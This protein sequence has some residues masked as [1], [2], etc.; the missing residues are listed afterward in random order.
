MQLPKQ[1][2]DGN[3]VGWREYGRQQEGSDPVELIQDMESRRNDQE[4]EQQ[5]WPGEEED[6]APVLS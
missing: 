6:G 3:R 2:K 5:P 1:T 4:R